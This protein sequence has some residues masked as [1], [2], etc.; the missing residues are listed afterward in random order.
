MTLMGDQKNDGKNEV[1]L[2]FTLT[3]SAG[4]YS[5]FWFMLKAYLYAERQSWDFYLEMGDWVYTYSKGWHD[6]FDSFTLWSEEYV[7]DYTTIHRGRHGLL[8]FMDKDFNFSLSDYQ[9]AIS[10]VYKLKKELVL[11]YDR[12]PVYR[13]AVMVRRGD[14]K[15]ECSLLEPSTIAQFIKNKVDGVAERG[16]N[17]DLYVQSDDIRVVEVIRRI[18]TSDDESRQVFS[19]TPDHHFGSYHH[20][21]YLSVAESSVKGKIVCWNEKTPEDRYHEFSQ[22][23]IGMEI[24]RHAKIVW[25]DYV[26]NVG[27]FLVLSS[28]GKV[29]TFPESKDVDYKMKAFPGYECFGF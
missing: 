21:G 14:K 19:L 17:S 29:V 6:Y 27:R 11:E 5:V 2:I 12:Y 26:S 25:T 9:R 1:A 8:P 20:Q 4:F 16:Q 3:S 18:Y 13:Y 7:S 10:E 28:S 22:F 23:L 24:C 15:T